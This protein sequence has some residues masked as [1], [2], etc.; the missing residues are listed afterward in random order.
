[1]KTTRARF[2]SSNFGRCVILT[3]PNGHVREF[4]I[5]RTRSGEG[6]VRE[7]SNLGPQVC[8]GL[9]STGETLRA[10]PGSLLTI[11]RREWRQYRQSLEY[12]CDCED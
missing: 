9:L 11:I 7:G 3:Q 6:Y 1:M 4:H 5:P 10:N 2:A 8:D 12:A